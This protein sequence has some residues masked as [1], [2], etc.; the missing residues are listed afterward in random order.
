MDCKY[1]GAIQHGSIA[2]FVPSSADHIGVHEM[3]TQRFRTIAIEHKGEVKWKYRGGV[4]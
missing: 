3:A 4:S 1:S 2:Y